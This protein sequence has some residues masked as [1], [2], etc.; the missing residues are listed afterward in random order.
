MSSS[1]SRKYTHGVEV[2]YVK[3]YEMVCFPIMRLDDDDADVCVCVPIARLPRRI[4]RPLRW[5]GSAPVGWRSERK[6]TAA[7]L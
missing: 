1:W 4:A 5:P 7:A 3:I 2:A 6:G